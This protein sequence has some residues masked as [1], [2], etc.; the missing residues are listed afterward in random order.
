MVFLTM[1]IRFIPDRAH[2]KRSLLICPLS[3][4]PKPLT[5]RE[6]LVLDR[7]DG[8]ALGFQGEMRQHV[9]GHARP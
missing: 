7:I 8:P 3:L 9:E 2:L 4:T 6:D 1:Y 5:I